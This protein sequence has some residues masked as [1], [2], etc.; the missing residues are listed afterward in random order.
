MEVI[1]LGIVLSEERERGRGEG[2]ARRFKGNYKNCQRETAENVEKIDKFQEI[3][4]RNY[5]KGSWKK[6]TKNKGRYERVKRKG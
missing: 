4:R 6:R 3:V 5:R 2:D 1:L